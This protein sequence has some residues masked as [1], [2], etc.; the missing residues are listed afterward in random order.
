MGVALA[1]PVLESLLPR[2]SAAAQ[3]RTIPRRLL[4]YYVPN[5]MNGSTTGA[6]RPSGTGRD[7]ALT[8]ILEPLGDLRGEV[9][10]LSGLSNR[11]AAASYAG[12]ND[13]PGDH[14]RG[15]GSFLTCARLR[16]TEGT[17]IQNGIS[18]DQVAAGAVG[19]ATRFPSLQLGV[20]GGASAGNCDSGYSC[21]YARNIS[22]ASATTPLPKLTSP[23]TIFDRLFAGG[24]EA[25]ARARRQAYQA[26]VLDYVREDATRLQGR[27]G[28]TD[29][30]KLE[31]YLTSVREVERR[32]A[33]GAGGRVCAP[34]ARPAEG[35]DFSRTLGV[36]HELMALA[37]QCDQTRVLT[38]MLGNA[39]SGRN[40][41]FLGADGGHHELSHHQ[42]DA[43]KL[44]ALQT[45][46]AFEVRQLALLLGRLRSLTESDGSTLLSHTAVLFS[47]EISDG[48]AHNHTNLP[49][50]LAGRLGGQLDP[51]RH[52]V[53]PGDPPIANLY[54]A[55]LKGMGVTAA[56]FGVEGDRVLPSLGPVSEG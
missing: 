46:G 44:A 23:G 13:G 31:E 5:G 39:G 25:A 29:R 48:D 22:W 28:A 40:Y 51:G 38:F 50:L 17:N 55:L 54:L 19:M 26:S 27:L 18:V 3:P 33:M 52:V 35:M 9:L 45:I 2:R 56:R 1:V 41:A 4:I 36:F 11:P 10:V 6:F 15:T 49:V 12:S 24:E 7:Y 8:P 16:K 30:R 47:S 37:I 20:D 43:R 34:P 53:Y 14:A 32:V 42:R 21:A